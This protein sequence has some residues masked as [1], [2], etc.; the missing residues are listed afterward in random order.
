MNNKPTPTVEDYLGIIYTLDRDGEEIYG[1]RLAELLNVSAPTV[2]VTLRRMVRD[3]WII[4]Y[5][6]KKISLTIKGVNAARA[7]IRR[8]MLTEWMLAKILGIPWSEIH[9]EADR[10]EHTISDDVEK[11]L[12]FTLDDPE[13][14]PHGNPMPGLETTSD[15]WSRIS[16]CQSNERVIIRR[17][18]EFLEDDLDTLRNLESFNIMPGNSVLIRK[19]DS[20]HQ[21]MQLLSSGKIVTLDYDISK[22]IFVEHLT[23]HSGEV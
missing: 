8:H 3:G 4:F 1:A 2:T 23:N 6:S 13:N 17:I 14:C 18:H 22:N 15:S 9:D 11:S 10:I 5:A 20:T 21:K 7:V 19:N 16:D 12:A